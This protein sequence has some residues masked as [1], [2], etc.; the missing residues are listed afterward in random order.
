MAEGTGIA[1][2]NRG[3]SF[4]LHPD[5]PDCVAPRQRPFRILTPALVLRHQQP[6]FSFGVMGCD[7]QP[8]RHVQ[9]LA[10]LLDFGTG[11]LQDGEAPRFRDLPPTG[12]MLE[13]AIGDYVRKGLSEK[14]HL[15]VEVDAVPGVFGGNQGILTDPASGALIGGSDLSKDRLAIGW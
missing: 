3:T 9:I 5:H 11:P 8:Q 14:G 10:N 2:H 15:L 6:Y 7:M 12:L 4:F 1:L 13:S